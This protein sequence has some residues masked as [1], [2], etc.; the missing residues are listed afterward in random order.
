MLIQGSACDQWPRSWSD[1]RFLPTG[2]DFHLHLGRAG[3]GAA[4]Q[5]LQDSWHSIPCVT[6]FAE[7]PRGEAS[8]LQSGRKAKK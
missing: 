5:T 4:P 6:G 7:E 8:G 3:D 1:H 2:K